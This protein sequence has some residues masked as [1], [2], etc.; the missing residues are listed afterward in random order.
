MTEFYI[1]VDIETN[2]PTPGSY[3]ML[4]FGAVALTESG[5]ELST[6]Q[7]NLEPL[8]DAEEDELTMKWWETQPKAWA[9][10][11]EDRKK[12]EDAIPAFARWVH[13]MSASRSS[14]P[15]MVA[16]PSGFDFMFMLWYLEKF[17]RG[18]NPFGFRCIDIRSFLAASLRVPYTRTGKR[19]WPK[20]WFDPELP[21]THVAIDDAREQGRA[22]IK[23]LSEGKMECR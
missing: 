21:H 7:A 5:T 1:S 4:S 22:F 15:V 9:A 10:L 17:Y 14:V 3:S 19:Y 12:P 18:H 13:T 11:L 8:A 6:F 2:G 23:M 16:Y 20:R